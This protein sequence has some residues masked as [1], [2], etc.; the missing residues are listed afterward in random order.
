MKVLIDNKDDLKDKIIDNVTLL[1]YYNGCCNYQVIILK[2]NE[3]AIFDNGLEL[4]SQRKFEKIKKHF[5]YD[6]LYDLS[7]IS[8]EERNEE[9]IW[10]NL[11]DIDIYDI[12]KKE[13][14]VLISYLQRHLNDKE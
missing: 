5:Y 13:K 8:D 11:I 4:I 12:N 3:I 10:E 6:D 14:E 2:H 1:D 7:L 9:N